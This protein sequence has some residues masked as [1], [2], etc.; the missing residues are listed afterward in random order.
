MLNEIGRL[1][2]Q[3]EDLPRATAHPELSVLELESPFV[4]A[5]QHKQLPHKF[6]ASLIPVYDRHG[7]PAKHV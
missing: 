2:R 5:I 4:E 7:D 3:F 1:K 6:Q